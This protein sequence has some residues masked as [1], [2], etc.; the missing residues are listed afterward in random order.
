MSGAFRLGLIGAGG[1]GRAYIRTVQGLDGLILT[2]VA[3]GN[4]ATSG[5]VGPACVVST[6]WH[7]VATAGD[8]DGV[9]VATPPGLHAVMTT[10]AVSA[11]N[12]VL[13]EKPLT[14]SVAEAERLRELVNRVDG[15]VVVDHTQLFSPVYEALRAMA[16]SLGRVRAVHSSAGGRGPFRHD[17]PVL[18]DWG[19]HDVATCIDLLGATPVESSA[20]VE[21]RRE[22]TNGWG[23][24]IRLDLRFDDDVRAELRLSNLLPSSQRQFSLELE[25]GSLS[26]SDQLGPR[27]VRRPRGGTEEFIDVSEELPLTRVVRYFAAAVAEGSRDRRD[28]DLGVSVVAVLARCES[29]V[30]RPIPR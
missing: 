29:S 10:T 23:E 13:V 16:P 2:R 24:A 28:L 15:L 6:D 5:L 20:T 3:S 22:T 8:L 9:I 1:W 19:A 21:E 14:M 25:G 11:G 17:V 26:Y 4:P 27:V 12:P 7:Q 30:T 18:W